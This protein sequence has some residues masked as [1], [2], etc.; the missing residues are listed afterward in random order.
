MPTSDDVKVKYPCNDPV[1][2]GGGGGGV[3]IHS[4]TL[5]RLVKMQFDT[6]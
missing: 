2:I 3:D 6:L 4:Q 5:R 1:E